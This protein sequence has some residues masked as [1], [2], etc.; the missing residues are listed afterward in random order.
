M[1]LKTTAGYRELH[2][3]IPRAVVKEVLGGRFPR[4]M[5]S[6]RGGRPVSPASDGTAGG[7]AARELPDE[8]AGAAHGRTPSGQRRAR[9]DA[10][11]GIA[12]GSRSPVLLDGTGGLGGWRARGRSAEVLWSGRNATVRVAGVVPE[13]GN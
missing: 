11:D 4:R 13:P 2:R 1:N 7:A 12:A 10:G 5:E 6:R 8:P 9:T 3:F